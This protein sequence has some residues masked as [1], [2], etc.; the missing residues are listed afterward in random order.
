MKH[1]AY[2]K[3]GQFLLSLICFAAYL[4]LFIAVIADAL[5]TNVYDF[6]LS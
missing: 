2:Q 1:E 6:I 4:F 5:N 3:L